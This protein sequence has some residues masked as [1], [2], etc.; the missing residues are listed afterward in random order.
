MKPSPE[1]GSTT[2]G[3]AG[4]CAGLV[5]SFPRPAQAP[6]LQ[7]TEESPKTMWSLWLAVACGFALLIGAWYVLFKVAHAAHV[8][9]VPL[10]TAEAKR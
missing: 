10:A 3:R 4:A 8:E 1:D 7:R 5:A 6:A 2:G 9:S